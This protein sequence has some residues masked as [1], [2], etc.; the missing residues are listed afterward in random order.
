MKLTINIFILIFA[1]VLLSGCGKDNYEPP[2]SKLTGK[3]I[4]NNQPV[5]VKGTGNTVQLEL[6]QRGY[7]LYTSIPVYVAQDGSF[8]ALLF[9]GKYKL[10]TRN[11][12]G[13][14][15]SKQDTIE[16]VVNGDTNVDYPVTPFFTISNEQ[17]SLSGKTLTAT[18]TVNQISGTQPVER[19]ILVVNKTAFVD[20][21]AQ[22]ARVDKIN[23]GTGQITITTD[24]SDAVMANA[25]LNARVGV[26]IQGREAIYSS[27]KKIK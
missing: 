21:T 24:L 10:V 7:Q 22:I 12:N 11:G 20:E 27:V 16:V 9:D 8:T 15:V 13:P 6:W 14:W 3:V 1:V 23:P 19:A 18:F 17:I 4:Y 26:K 2:K 5:G 25:L